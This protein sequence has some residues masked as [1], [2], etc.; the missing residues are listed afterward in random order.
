MEWK[1]T[2]KSSF[3]LRARSLGVS[4]P[5][6]IVIS[7]NIAE[8]SVTIDDVVFVIDSGVKKE[9]TY[10][11]ATNMPCLDATLVAK[12]NALQRK[13][14]GKPPKRRTGPTARQVRLDGRLVGGGVEKLQRV[15]PFW[16]DSEFR[17]V[18]RAGFGP[19]SLTASKLLISPPL[20]CAS[21]LPIGPP[22]LSVQPCPTHTKHTKEVISVIFRFQ[23]SIP[24]TLSHP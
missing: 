20:P 14:G 7:T 5:G 18:Q 19:A 15:T 8:S 17:R 3:G 12:A 16:S 6:Q 11:P 10:D 4:L 23:M 1:E 13:G 21:T 22:D 9:K 24:P 2:E